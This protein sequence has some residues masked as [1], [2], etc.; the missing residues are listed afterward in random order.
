[1]TDFQIWSITANNS[2]AM[3]TNERKRGVWF[4]TAKMLLQMP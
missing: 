2:K 3:K 1:M 4:V